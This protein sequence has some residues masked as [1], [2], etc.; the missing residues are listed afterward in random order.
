MWSFSI[1]SLTCLS[2]VFTHVP[3]R[4]DARSGSCPHDVTRDRLLFG[5]IRRP[6]CVVNQ[7]TP[8][9]VCQ[10]L[11]SCVSAKSSDTDAVRLPRNLSTHCGHGLGPGFTR[12]FTGESVLLLPSL[13]RFPV[14]PPVEP[15]SRNR[16]RVMHSLLAAL[17]PRH[18][19]QGRSGRGRRRDV[20]HEKRLASPRPDRRRP[21]RGANPPDGAGR[22]VRTARVRRR[23]SLPGPASRPC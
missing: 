3:H 7:T 21:R 2:S 1:T 5:P 4:H 22:A 10:G 17:R 8:K 19:V 15:T 20:D 16:G 14:A 18:A 9:D 12:P 13:L 23:P 11:R 6:L